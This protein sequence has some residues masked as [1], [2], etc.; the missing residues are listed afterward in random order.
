MKM[1]KIKDAEKYNRK[2]QLHRM[3]VGLPPPRFVGAK[4]Y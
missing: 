3:S 1:R 4:E 2:K